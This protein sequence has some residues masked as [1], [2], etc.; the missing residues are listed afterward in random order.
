MKGRRTFLEIASI[1]NKLQLRF[2]PEDNVWEVFTTIH[3]TDIFRWFKISEST[4]DWYLE[5]FP[6]LSRFLPIKNG[7]TK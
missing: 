4:K 5:N 1:R 3:G 7:E 6:E 2:L